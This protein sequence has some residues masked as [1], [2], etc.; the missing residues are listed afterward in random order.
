MAELLN[1]T[2]AGTFEHMKSADYLAESGDPKW[3][4][5]L[6]EVAKKNARIANYLNDAAELGGDEMLPVLSALAR[7]P[8]KEF[9]A[10]NA[11]TAMGY[12]GSRTAV[13]I[14]LDF[15]QSSD[16][17]L[18]DRARYGLRLLTH[19]TA[20][21]EPDGSHSPNT[22]GGRN[23]GPGKVQPLLSTRPRNAQIWFH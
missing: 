14:L 13:P 9:T 5:L 10:V 6:L 8:D 21:N 19:R 22:P 20:T 2:E 16:P 18:S 3:F 1:M 12:T 11:V 15:L 23:G 4:P 7:D 17:G